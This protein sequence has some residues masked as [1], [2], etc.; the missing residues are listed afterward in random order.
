MLGEHTEE[1]LKSLAGYS[2]R[3][4]EGLRKVGAI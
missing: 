1:V 2:E 4:I 3:D